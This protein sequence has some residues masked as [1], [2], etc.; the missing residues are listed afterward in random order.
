MNIGQILGN[1][2][3]DSKLEGSE[4]AKGRC[5]I[6]TSRIRKELNE[7]GLPSRIIYAENRKTPLQV[8]RDTGQRSNHYAIYFPQLSRVVD[9]TM[10]QFNP[11]SEY[12]FV[13]TQKEWRDMLK[14]SWDQETIYSKTF[15]SDIEIKDWSSLL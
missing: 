8:F 4:W 6:E 14:K 3:Q 9:Y 2:S 12:P 15:D 13:G 11:E 10:R 1:V 5:H 7:K